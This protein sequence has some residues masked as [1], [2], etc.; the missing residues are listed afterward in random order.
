MLA[1]LM[2]ISV[3]RT[4]GLSQWRPLLGCSQEGVLQ[5]ML[6]GPKLGARWRLA[7]VLYTAYGEYLVAILP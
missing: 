2:V 3:H 4:L 5:T 6:L 1:L 7:S